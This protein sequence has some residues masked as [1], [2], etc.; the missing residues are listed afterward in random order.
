MDN[1]LKTKEKTP[2]RERANAP[3]LKGKPKTFL[4]GKELKTKYLHHTPA[5]RGKTE[6]QQNPT[7]NQK[8]AL[9]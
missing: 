3:P 1:S 8:Q 6:R 7:Q 2:A 9:G 5:E 4:I